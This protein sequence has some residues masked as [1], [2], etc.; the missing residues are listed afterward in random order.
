[1]R[2]PGVGAEYKPFFMN[3]FMVLLL[4]WWLKSQWRFPP[5][6]HRGGKHTRSGNEVFCQMA[7]L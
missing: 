4:C 3:V 1:M 7:C 2:V 6:M 5:A